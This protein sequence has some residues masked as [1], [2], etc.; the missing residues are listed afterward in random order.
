M[1][2]Y[3][4]LW[5]AATYFFFLQ[6]LRLMLRLASVVGKHE[7][8]SHSVNQSPCYFSLRERKEGHWALPRFPKAA[9]VSHLLGP[10][11][12]PKGFNG[13]VFWDSHAP[14]VFSERW[15][16]S[17]GENRESSLSVKP[18]K[19]DKASAERGAAPRP[20]ILFLPS[21][22]ADANAQ[23]QLPHRGLCEQQSQM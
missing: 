11:Q 13:S 6:V 19:G 16:V 7:S 4:C 5:S 9:H 17:T 22:C 12:Q 15:R 2:F 1:P 3:Q 20:L 21:T 10:C 23:R 8:D 14:S 18:L